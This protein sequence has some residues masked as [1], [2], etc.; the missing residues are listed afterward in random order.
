MIERELKL[1]A[2]QFLKNTYDID[3]DVPVKINHRLRSTYG[4]FVLRQGKPYSIE[5]ASF[6]MDYADAPVI[7]DILRHECIHYAL[8]K[9]KLPYKD[10]DKLFKQELL[11]HATSRTRTLKIGKYYLYI[12]KS[13]ANTMMSTSTKLRQKPENYISKCCRAPLIPQG[14]R[15]F[16][17]S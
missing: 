5:I 11:R 8:F 17:G 3:I 14:H 15:I 1:Y 13:C 9:K 7:L 4:R 10:K 2:S 6:V 16:R 12:C